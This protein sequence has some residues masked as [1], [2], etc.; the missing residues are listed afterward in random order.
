MKRFAIY[1]APEEGPFAS[2]AAAW[3]GYD[4][5]SGQTV[6]QP[7]FDL[8][9]SLADAT[10]APRK[11]GF[12]ATLKAPFRL[13]EGVTQQDLS[14]ALAALAAQIPSVHLTG[15]RLVDLDGFL[16][17]VPQDPSA[18]LQALC[19]RLVQDLDGFRAALTPDEIARRRPDRLTPRQRALLEIYGY[20]YVLEEFFFHMTLTG[21]L[22]LHEEPAFMR[23]I[24]THFADSV[25][26]PLVLASVCLMGEDATGR[27]HLLERHALSA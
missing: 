15:L 14:A 16:A 3:L 17:L 23:A 18:A 21:Q 22:A 8:P 12:H 10:A 4:V 9:R 11:Y 26:Q 2:A 13:A 27:F 20:P 7:R 24:T 1:Y 19:A 5:V 6:A 25:P